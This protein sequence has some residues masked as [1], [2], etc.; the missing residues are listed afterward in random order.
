M[1]KLDLAK[2]FAPPKPPKPL[3]PNLEAELDA[4]RDGKKAMSMLGVTLDMMFDPEL[5]SYF[6]YILELATEREL[7]VVLHDDPLSPMQK[8]AAPH[9]LVTRIDE[10]WRIPALL[11]VWETGDSRSTAAELQQSLLLGFTPAQWK[12]WER[13]NHQRRPFDTIVYALLTRAQR[14]RVVAHGKRC[15]GGA[16]DV[17]AIDFFV[18]A[19]W[20]PKPTAPRLVPRGTTLARVSIEREGLQ[21]LFGGFSRIVKPQLVQARVAPKGGAAFNASIRNE[22]QFL[23]SRGWR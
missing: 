6:F 11:A 16:D 22:V 7:V 18:H 15:L 5:E 19:N 14:A 3:Y 17:E 23:S 9:V 12:K 2:L 4:I 8:G 20:R 10:L 13:W 1:K 21:S